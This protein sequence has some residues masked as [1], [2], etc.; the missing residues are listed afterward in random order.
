VLKV[1]TEAAHQGGVIDRC[2]D[3]DKPIRFERETLPPQLRLR[4]DARKR[5][6]RFVVLS[7]QTDQCF[8]VIGGYAS[9]QVRS[10]NRNYS[11][12]ST[13]HSIRV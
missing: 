1:V 10:G 13:G 5:G 2:F 3:Q 11:P 6:S 8:E 9:S 7:G 12:S 4:L